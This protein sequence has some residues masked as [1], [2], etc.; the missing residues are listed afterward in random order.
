[1]DFHQGCKACPC[2]RRVEADT[3]ECGHPRSAHMLVFDPPRE[4]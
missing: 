4:D 2:P 1:M 3:C